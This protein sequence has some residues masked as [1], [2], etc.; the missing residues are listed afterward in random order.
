[1]RLILILACVLGVAGSAFAQAR[2]DDTPRTAVISAFGPE[3][4][5]LEAATTDKHAYAV[6][7]ATFTTGV[8]E[9]KPVVLFLSGMS[10]VNAA[11]TT[12]QALDRF[13]VTRVVF[14]GIAGGVDPALDVGD[15][16][17]AEQWAQYLENALGRE[18]APGKFEPPPGE[19]LAD[20]LTPFGMM[21]P[22]GVVVT[23]TPGVMERKV[24]FPADPAMFATAREV[25]G[26]VT[27]K[28]CTADR[29]LVKPPR[30][31]V[32]GNGVSGQ[33]FVDNA[34][35]R[36][37]AYDAF[38][39]RVLDMESAAVAQ[40][41]YVNATPFIAF[42]SLSDLAGGDPGKNQA[43]TFFQLASD[44]SAAVVRAFLAALP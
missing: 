31:V 7:G 27:L 11:M 42:R 15:V 41:A 9:G 34:Q 20:K 32:G 4:T 23:R 21:F 17:V 30:V 44:N 12:Q 3:L 10:M 8:L 24:W 26:Q 38:G 5:A 6:A 28:R 13:K 25:A 18:I 29:C 2:L 40:V 39:A 35:F 16:V 37:W 14:S 43:R 33:S 1:M 22:R 19:P 36:T